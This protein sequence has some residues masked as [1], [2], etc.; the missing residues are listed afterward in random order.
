MIKELVY[1]G[2]KTWRMSQKN[3]VINTP[4]SIIEKNYPALKLTKIIVLLTACLFFESPVR[5]LN[6]I[7]NSPVSNSP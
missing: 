4:R 7:R 1:L 5:E 6:C 3:K 2:V